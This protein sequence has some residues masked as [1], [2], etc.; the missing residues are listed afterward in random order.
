[1]ILKGR[2]ISSGK[3]SGKVLKLNGTFSFLGG[4][5]AST[6]EL[7]EGGGNIAGKIFVFNGGKGSTVGS[8]VMY[9]L[10]V[11]GK[12][13]AAVVNSSAETIVT[14]G[15]VIS[16]IPMIDKIDVDLLCNDDEV[17]V[18]GDSGTIEIKN[19]KVIKVVSSAIINESGKV[20][21]LQRPD[22]ARSFPGRKSLV[23]GKVEGTEDTESAA[24]REIMEET[25][26][27]VFGSD[28]CL[29]PIYVREHDVIWEVHPFL[30][31]VKDPF[32]NLNHENV[33]FEWI[34]PGMIGKDQSI[35]PQTFDVV[36]RMLKELK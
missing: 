11:H 21:L 25:Q 14:T 27:K 19:M 15:A 4:V 8:F 6:G 7:N 33:G 1:M 2:A 23:A 3:V 17:T 18:D 24:R 12:A 32:P 36:G 30:F 26:I 31:R 9:D 13:P 5:N 20:L 22:K 16:S 35:V 10:M 29:P 28:A 34:D